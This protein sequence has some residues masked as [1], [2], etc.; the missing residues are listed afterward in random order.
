MKYYIA[1]FFVFGALNLP[2]AQMLPAFGITLEPM[3]IPD[4]GGLQSYAFGQ[5]DG[6]WLIVGGRLDGL[7]RRQPFAAFD[8]IGHNNQLI[9]IDPVQK[10]KWSVPLT[11]LTFPQQEQLRSTNM[12]FF[13][14]ANTLYLAGGYGYSDMLEDHTTFPFLTAINVPQIISAIVQKTDFQQFVRQVKDTVFQ[15]TGGRLNKLGDTFYLVGGHTFL[16]PYNPA[17][18]AFGPG[19][20]QRYTDQIRKF[21]IIDDTKT[22]KIKHLAPISDSLNLHRRDYNL[23]AQMQYP[24]KE[25]LVAFGG[26]FQPKTDLPYLN[27]VQIDQSGHQV[28][29]DFRQHYNHYHCPHIGMYSY[30]NQD[31][32]TFFFGGIAEFYDSLHLLV[33]DQ[34]MPFTKT[35]SRVTCMRNGKKAEFKLP[36]EMPALLGAG[37]EFI[38]ETSLPRYPNGVLKMDSIGLDTTLLGYIYGGIQSTAPHI[39]WVNEDAQSQASSTIYRVKMYR[40]AEKSQDKLQAASTNKLMLQ[41]YVPMQSDSLEVSYTLKTEEK[42]VKL[43]VIL[44]NKVHNYAFANRIAG[45]HKEVVK[46]EKLGKGGNALILLQTTMAQS[47]VYL[48]VAKP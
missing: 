15:V 9:V 20:V 34:D 37:A 1:I 38:P 3:E 46:V 10:K 2:K 31:M 14:A 7:H 30:L 39:F 48:K 22:L 17:G 8:Q 40:N 44:D 21:E 35:I 45:A 16:G 47:Q 12:Q 5:A 23:V 36:I 41:V 24:D 29:T 27:P 18:A 33:Q 32:H 28:V 6:K 26:V 43:M 42:E 25:S 19:F 13:Q 4:L 11:T